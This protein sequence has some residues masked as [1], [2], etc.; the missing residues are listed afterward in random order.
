[1]ALPKRR[2]SHARV[3][4]RRQQWKA[5]TITTTSCPHCAATIVP[6]RAC[7]TCG[8]YNGRQVLPP[9]A[10]NTPRPDSE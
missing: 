4:T 1:M 10:K 3:R 7:L 6:H 2:K 8:Y 5:K 9:R